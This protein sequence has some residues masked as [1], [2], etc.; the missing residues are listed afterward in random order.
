MDDLAQ[1]LYQFLM[2]RRMG[3]LWKDDEYRAC[4]LSVELQKK[5][6]EGILNLEQRKELD[7]LLER[8]AERDCIE[9]R[10]QFQAV[11]K[12]VQELHVLTG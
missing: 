5:R 11:L 3:Y 7:R 9:N 10:H 2:E 6:V 4:T 1:C 12:L 8:M